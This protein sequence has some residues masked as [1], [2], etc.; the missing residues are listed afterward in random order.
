MKVAKLYSFEDIRIED[1]PVPGIGPGDALVR[2]K[3]CGIC[4]GDVMPWYIG[5]K[6][7]LVL[8]HE[9]AG[10]I[11]KV[12]RMVKNFKYGDRVFF[13]HHAPCFMCKYCKKGDY[14]QCH[15]WKDSKIIPGGISEYVLI[16]GVNL[17]GDTLLLQGEVSFEEA[18]LI[19]P[20]ACVIK[21]LKRAKVRQGDT[22]LV[23]GLGVMGQIHII[24]AKRYGAEKI[25]G[26]DRIPYRLQHAKE[27]GAHTVID[28][29]RV[30]FADAIVN[31]TCGD[32]ADVVVVGPGDV[33]AMSQGIGC[34]GRGGRVLFFTPARPE[35]VLHVKP[36]EIYFRDINIITS[37]SCGPD[38]T[39]EALALI[40]DGVFNTERLITH[41]FPM[42][43]TSEAFRLT[44]TAKDSLKVVVTI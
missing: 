11:V 3:A 31:E 18:T 41:K 25:I 16:P 17:Q 12:G 37:Y 15:T 35:D 2:V 24:L 19:E 20:V 10:E 42:E 34:A 40:S 13:H 36:N 7:P 43:K 5:T 1:M 27:F 44:A 30:E 22:V 4:S 33:E 28:V 32:M 14:V 21:G 38:D 26:A 6:A 9:P 29:S 39:K 8:G 23:M